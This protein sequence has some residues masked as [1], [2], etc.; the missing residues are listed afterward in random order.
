MGIDIPSIK[1]PPSLKNIHI[2]ARNVPK[3]LNVKE[4]TNC[5]HATVE[6]V[7][8]PSYGNP[9]DPSAYDVIESIQS[10]IDNLPSSITKLGLITPPFFEDVE[11]QLSFNNFPELNDLSTTYCSLDQSSLLSLRNLHVP[12]CTI[13][14]EL[15]NSLKSLDLSPAALLMMVLLASLLYLPVLPTRWNHCILQPKTL[16]YQPS[17]RV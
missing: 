17:G 14:E 5:T 4:L 9:E 3:I 6:F 1:L 8:E 16:F 12:E 7:Q 2:S 15:P 13:N 10:S 11:K